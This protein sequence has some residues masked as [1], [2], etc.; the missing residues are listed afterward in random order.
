M[1]DLRRVARLRPSDPF[2]ILVVAA[3]LIRAEILLRRRPVD[4][5]AA[6]FAMRFDVDEPQHVD[7]VALTAS[8]RRWLINTSRV[9][10]RW[11][12][13]RS[14]LRRSLV[15]GWVLRAHE[16]ELVIGTRSDGEGIHVHAW[17]RIGTH[18]LDATAGDH[19][20]FT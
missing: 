8:E 1:G 10:R 5:A 2:Q 17:V 15:I 3:Q 7:A 13:D 14:C 20:A 11:P 4:R 9:L 6:G 18:D 12:F 19:A 16:P